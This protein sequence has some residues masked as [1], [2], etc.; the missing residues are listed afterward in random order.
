MTGA[1]EKIL[2]DVKINY[3]DVE[4]CTFYI[5]GW[6]G[7][8]ERQ[9]KNGIITNLPIIPQINDLKLLKMKVV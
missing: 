7:Q 1:F 4:A 2:N 8:N 3:K 5:N 9:H 6:V